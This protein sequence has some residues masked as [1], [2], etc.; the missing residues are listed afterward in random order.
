MAPCFTRL[1]DITIDDDETLKI[2]TRVVRMWY[3]KAS[4]LSN[5]ISTI[6]LVLID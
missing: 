4:W 5:E 1:H 6:D 3:T 2:E